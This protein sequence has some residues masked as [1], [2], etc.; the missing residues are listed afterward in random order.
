MN[1]PDD[2]SA[3]AWEAAD[4][5]YDWLL[6]CWPSTAGGLPLHTRDH[7]AR[8]IDAAIAKERERV[9]KAEADRDRLVEALRQ[10]AWK[11]EGVPM[12]SLDDDLRIDLPMTAGEI[13][14]MLKA[15]EGL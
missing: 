1:K 12:N 13:R 14:S 15:L 8:A 11:V 2:V 6:E 10:I 5:H 3:E 7:L 9:D 4:G